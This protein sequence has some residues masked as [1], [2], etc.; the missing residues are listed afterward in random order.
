MN[1][2]NEKINLLENGINRK[3]TLDFPIINVCHQII[4]NN[5]WMLIW[6]K[7]LVYDFVDVD[8]LSS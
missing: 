1:I 7:R 3:C 4:T 8:M 6:L 5:Y 2:N